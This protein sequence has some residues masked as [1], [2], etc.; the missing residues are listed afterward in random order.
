MEPGPTSAPVV[1]ALLDA[2]CVVV[3]ILAV[4]MRVRTAEYVTAS[5]RALAIGVP[6]V[7]LLVLAVWLPGGPAGAR[8]GAPRG[9]AGQADRRRAD[10]AIHERAGCR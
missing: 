4:W 2:I 9:N 3:V 5:G 1:D 10:D 6:A 8:L 7:F